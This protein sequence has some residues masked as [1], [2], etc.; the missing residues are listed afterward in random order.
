MFRVKLFSSAAHGGDMTSLERE[1]NSWLEASEPA[2][3][4]MAQSSD[5]GR[6]VVTFLYEKRRG[7]DQAHLATAD[8]PD[9]FERDLDDTNLDPVEDELPTLPEAELP[10]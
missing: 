6:V 3:R 10:Y 4:Q 8:V 2:I 9:A 1:I 7:E 5:A